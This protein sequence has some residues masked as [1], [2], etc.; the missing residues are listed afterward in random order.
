MTEQQLLSIV[1]KNSEN[2][3]FSFLRSFTTE[4]KKQLVPVIKKLI[5]HFTQFGQISGNSYGYINGSNEQRNLM[6]YAAFGCFNRADYE[7]TPFAVWILDKAHL[8]KF[9]DWY[10]PVWFNDFVNK[11]ADQDFI[12]YYLTYEW[13]M[14]LRAKGILRPTKELLVKAL[15]QVIFEQN[16]KRKWL[17]KPE[18]LLKEKATLEEHVWYLFETESNIHYSGRY[19]QLEDGVSKEQKDWIAVFL[20]YTAEG[21]LDR[22]RVIKE[23]LLAGNRNFNKVLSGWFAQLF[24]DMKPTQEECMQLQSE[25][26]SVLSSPQSKVV[27]TA[28]QAIKNL[29][30]EKE[31]EI[32]AFLDNIPILVSSDT[33]AIVLT[34]LTILEKIAKQFPS[35]REKIVLMICQCFIHADESLQSKVAKIIAKYGDEKN[36]DLQ[37]EIEN[38]Y[39]SML[40]TPHQ[41]L[42]RFRKVVTDNAEETHDKNEQHSESESGDLRE[43]LFPETIDDLF[44]LASQAFDNNEIWHIDMLPAALIYFQPQLKTE[45]IQRFEPAFQRAFGLIKGGY[46]A[47]S[48]YLDSLLAHFFIDYGNWLIVNYPS[49]SES[50]KKIYISKDEKIGDKTSSFLVQPAAGSYT[51]HWQMHNK[52]EIYTPYKLFLLA[53]LNK[54]KEKDR[55]PLLSTPTHEPCWVKAEVIIDR[56]CTY[57]E[58]GK[59]PADIDLQIAISRCLLIDNEIEIENAAQKLSGEF[60]HLVTFLFSNHSKPE[61]PFLYKAAWMVASLTRKQKKQWLEFESFS[62]YRKAINNYTGELK[63]NSVIENYKFNKYDF[64]T[65]KYIDVPST[66]KT[67]AVF[68]DS[69]TNEKKGL[70]KIFTN[71]LS[72]NK[73]DPQMLYEFMDFNLKYWSIEHNDIKRILSLVPNNPESVLAAVFNNSL[74]HPEFWEETSKRTVIAV[75]EMLYEIWQLPGEIAKLFLGTCMLSGNKTVINIAGEIWLKAVSEK[76]INNSELGIIIGIHERIEFA[77]LKRL[78]DLITQSLFRVSRLHNT[79][80]QILIENIL[81]QLPNEP[82]KN[83]KKLLEIYNELLSINKSSIQLQEVTSR[84]KIWESNAGLQKLTSKLIN[85]VS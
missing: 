60:L 22:F 51:A 74:Q 75:I 83:L 69:G 70:K 11:Q 58:A 17:F 20:Q 21:R 44:F 34:T 49:A 27:N 68:R 79:E 54:I 1:S 82:I 31:F 80:L 37:N 45:D 42:Q 28:L 47:N 19:L 43:I 56:L 26:F 50:I 62:Y 36:I 25:L 53:A 14:E 61:K 76:K 30:A 24:T 46:R 48:G 10:C 4:E 40:S 63:W 66:R 78:T 8:N 32:S 64:E 3:L 57:Q 39:P 59:E 35:Y 55:L 72:N 6:Q 16:D 85:W 15:P 2:D 81:I 29:V 71:L 13:M 38:F 33:K 9:I 77:P 73:L 23:A 52:I 12:P 41:L 67:A 7:K 5:K 18:K 65:K 84:L